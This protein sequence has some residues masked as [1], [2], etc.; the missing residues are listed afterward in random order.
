MSNTRRL[1]ARA[2]GHVYPVPESKIHAPE[3]FRALEDGAHMWAVMAAFRL[4]DESAARTFTDSGAQVMMD[5]ENLMSVEG[6][7]CILCERPWSAQLAAE[8]C[9]GNPR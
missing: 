5:Q 4:S 9:P 8:R 3:A 2:T 1:R 7:G 6:P